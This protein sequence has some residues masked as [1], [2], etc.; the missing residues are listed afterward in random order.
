MALTPEQKSSRLFKKSLGAGE[1][2]LAR[3]FFEEP[4]L[5]KD[6]IFTDQI[7]AES[8]K[9]P[10]TAPTLP[11]EGTSGVVQY[12]EKLQLTHVPGSLNLAYYSEDLKDTI[13]FNFS[14]GSY[15]YALFRDD[16]TTI[17]FGL[18]DWLVDTT[19]GLLT[20]YGTLPSGVSAAAPPKISFYKYIG[21][22]GVPDATGTGFNIKD[23]V[24]LATTDDDT[25]LSGYDTDL[26]GFTSIPLEIDSVSGNTLDEGDRVL[27]KNQDSNPLQNGI[28]VVSGTTLVR[29]DAIVG[30]GDYVF[31]LGGN[32]NIASSWVL[33]DTDAEDESEIISGVDTQEWELFARSVAY[34]AG[35]GL[36]LVGQEFQV[37]V[38]GETIEINLDNELE[39]SS[40]VMD[41]IS[42]NT[43][44]I[45]VLSSETESLSTA[46]SN[47]EDDILEVSGF[48]QTLESA[49]ESNTTDISTLS[50]L[51]EDILDDIESLETAVSTLSGLTEGVDESIESLSTA[52]DALSGITTENTQ[53]IEELISDLETE[54]S[55]RESEALT[56]LKLSGGTMEGNINLG[57]N[58]IIATEA[59]L[60]PE[61]LTNKAY[62]D[63]IAQGLKVK[64]KVVL[65]TTENLNANYN[66]PLGPGEPSGATLTANDDGEF[67]L[68][69]VS[70]ETM[71]RILVKDQTNPIHNGIY[72]ITDVGS[73]S[74]PWVLTR[75]SDYDD[76]PDPEL[77]AGDYF[78][79]SFG[80]E[81]GATGWVVRPYQNGDPEVG[82][83]PIIFIQF[84]AVGAFTAGDALDLDGNEFNVKY[85]GNTITT[86]VD[87]ELEVAESIMTQISE[88]TEDIITLTGQTES[89]S[90]A[91]SN[92]ED[93]ILTLSGDTESLETAINNNTT[94]IATLSGLT[95]DILDDISDL[96]SSISTNT[97]DI[98]D[99]QTS[100]STN[101][102]DIGVLSGLTSDI[103]EDI[104]TL[105]GNTE[106]LESAIDSNATDIATL[107][108]NTE[109]LETAI[110]SNASDISDLSGATET[111]STA[112]ETEISERISGDS[113]LQDAIVELSGATIDIE[114]IL[115]EGELLGLVDGELT[116]V[117]NIQGLLSTDIDILSGLTSTLS[118]DLEA[119]ESQVSINT[120]DIESLELAFNNF[121]GVTETT[122][123]SGLTYDS[124]TQSLNVNVD[125]VTIKISGDTLIGPREWQDDDTGITITNT[126]GGTG[127]ILEFDPITPVNAYVNGVNYFVNPGTE[128]APSRP[129]FYDQFPPQIGTEIWFDPATAGFNIEPFDTISIKYLITEGF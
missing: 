10:T 12:F 9:I 35:A 62:V 115:G 122:A 4:R 32:E 120:S 45:V 2:L 118:S 63:A 18:G 47:L 104:S 128:P 114:E 107:S 21:K 42:E 119:L 60:D 31:V 38:D 1:T 27:I 23:P 54:I 5:G 129:F 87:D 77:F 95:E 14:D 80:N 22:K 70:G 30:V 57:D 93:D 34:E 15:N 94:D 43:S 108:G 55:I 96:E 88:N 39:V 6:A 53:S 101:T 113:S 71:M 85:D 58:F 11:N 72:K 37:N 89:L 29:A 76:R 24:L 121:S 92:L 83:D 51:T 46:V 79:V 116:G 110:D 20:F 36:S 78:F 124:A 125:G 3:D 44:D 56:Y 69:G 109:S 82:T 75:S 64:D 103:L 106:S 105:S 50:G 49:I 81:N 40:S 111:L 19:A 16:D 127:L 28:Y 13:P 8:D 68:D 126:S 86:N 33:N 17:A 66:E 90:T 97:S 99:L 123:G 26:S 59:P 84:S 41:Q 100:V 52:V 48:T 102:S 117:T 25:D 67:F 74:D 61:H 73:P 65:A 7:W 112:L 98:S 91:V